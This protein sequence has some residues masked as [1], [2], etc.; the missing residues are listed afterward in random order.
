MKSINKL[1]IFFLFSTLIF[2]NPHI[3]YADQNSNEDT[4]DNL[5]AIGGLMDKVIDKVPGM[6]GGDAPDMGGQKTE[7][8]KLFSESS[9]YYMTAQAYLLKSLKK[10]EEAQ[11]VLAGI[12][13]AKNSKNSDADRMANSIKVSDD[14]SK[15]IESSMKGGS[16]EL[17]AESKVLYAQSLPPA[18]KGVIS[19]IKLGPVAQGM[20]A[21]IQANP[22]SA[23]D[24]LGGLAKVIP[25]VPGYISTLTNTMKLVL[26]A[27][28]ANN[29]D[30][31]K[32]FE[33]VLSDLD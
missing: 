18:G 9:E 27:A 31:T 4:M 8:V 21:T 28:K 17:T 2:F 11:K 12:E 24:Q 25:K 29:V 26:T 10:D 33:A 30:G 23:L 20:V 15:V 7:L 13:F 22:M 3:S 14:A 32:D 16:I 19:T 1:N 5:Y 6:G